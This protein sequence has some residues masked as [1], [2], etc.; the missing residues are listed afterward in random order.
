MEG[1][2]FGSSHLKPA[3]DEITAAFKRLHQRAFL[4]AFVSFADQVYKQSL[5][6]AFL[7]SS[8]L[9]I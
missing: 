6:L 1:G 3:P 2:H 5:I 9:A 4:K 8:T 7:L